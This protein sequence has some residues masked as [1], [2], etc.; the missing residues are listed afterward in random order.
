[1]RSNDA[2]LQGVVMK[3]LITGDTNGLAHG[4]C[5]KLVGEAAAGGGD[6]KGD[7]QAQCLFSAIARDRK[8]KTMAFGRSPA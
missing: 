4:H 1:M 8:E 3:P 2:E 6:G 5:T 7:A